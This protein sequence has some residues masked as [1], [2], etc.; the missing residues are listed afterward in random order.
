MQQTI[1]KQHRWTDEELVY[2]FNNYEH[3]HESIRAIVKYLNSKLPD[4]VKPLTFFSVK[5]Q[6]RGLK[7]SEM[8]IFDYSDPKPLK[9]LFS[10]CPMCGGTTTVNETAYCRSCLSTWHAITL[11]PM[12]YVDKDG[13]V[14]GLHE[15]DRI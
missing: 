11:Q 5:N 9:M 12:T 4:G 3:T 6:V 13:K 10:R 8:R 7:R 15:P 14:H 2:L 1:E